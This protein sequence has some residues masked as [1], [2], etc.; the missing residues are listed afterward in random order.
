MAQTRLEVS[1]TSN[2]YVLTLRIR[3]F[4]LSFYF[5]FF[6]LLLFF[7]SLCPCSQA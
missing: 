1:E 3:A 6:F 4:F 5:H 7:F 2:S